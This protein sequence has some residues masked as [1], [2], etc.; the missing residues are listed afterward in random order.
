MKMLLISDVHSNIDALNAVWD[1]ESDADC[2]YCA[3]DLVDYGFFPHEVIAWCREHEVQAVA[4]NHDR[5]ITAVASGRRPLVPGTFAAYNLERLDEDDLAY[6]NALPAEKRFVLDGSTYYMTHCCVWEDEASYPHALASYS[7]YQLFCGLWAQRMSSVQCADAG[8][9]PTDNRR[10]IAGHTHHCGLHLPAPDSCM[11]NP[12][13]VSYRLGGDSAM[14]GADYMVIEDGVIL[15]RHV[16][17]PSAHL[18]DMVEQAGFL[19]DQTAV[20]RSFYSPQET[21]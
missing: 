18:L 10:I 13:S 17:Y 7:S 14:K 3:G 4:G 1:R 6:L 5:E 16:A 8:I 12:G 19:P 9:V 20:G 21:F 11:L 2:I 15:P